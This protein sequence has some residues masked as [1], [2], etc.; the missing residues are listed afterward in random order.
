M[1][2]LLLLF[3]MDVGG[4]SAPLPLSAALSKFCSML[5]KE[6]KRRSDSYITQ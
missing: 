6:R 2:G 4:A 3:V 1:M 5:R